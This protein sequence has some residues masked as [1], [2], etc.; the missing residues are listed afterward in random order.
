[1][2]EKEITFEKHYSFA[3]ADAVMTLLAAR[4]WWSDDVPDGLTVGQR[5]TAE[6][7]NNCREQGYAVSVQVGRE[8]MTFAFGQDRNCDTPV[9]FIGR[10]VAWNDDKATRERGI[11]TIDGVVE[12]IHR[13]ISRC[14][15]RQAVVTTP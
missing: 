11:S 5:A 8:R 14:V 4:P 9:L 13:E 10:N 15:A 7:W 6:A 2:E 3:I 1:M 12:R